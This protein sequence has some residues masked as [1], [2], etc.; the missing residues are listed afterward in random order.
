MPATEE[1]WQAI[2]DLKAEH[3]AE[4]ADFDEA[5]RCRRIELE[6]Q[7]N[8]QFDRL[9]REMGAGRQADFYGRPRPTTT[10]QG[11]QDG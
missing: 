6:A 5:C 2:T 8:G 1:Q 9:Y 4:L 3:A 7:Q 10:T 11:E